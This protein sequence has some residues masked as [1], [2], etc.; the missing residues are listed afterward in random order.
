MWV[1]DYIQSF[2]TFILYV[3]TSKV[4]YICWTK[5]KL[6]FTSC[7]ANLPAMSDGNKVCGI[8]DCQQIRSPPHTHTWPW[9]I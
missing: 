2:S 1:S 9:P 8:S 3:L 4:Q 5:Y 7:A 6:L